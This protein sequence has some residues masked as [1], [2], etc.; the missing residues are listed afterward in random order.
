M[1]R[2][3]TDTVPTMLT[4]GEFVI[5][6]EAVDM[7][8]VPFLKKLN[9]VADNA[10]H[11]SIDALIAQAQMESMKTMKGGGEVVQGY[12]NGGNVE[13]EGLL[14]GL[15]SMLSGVNKRQKAYE[16]LVP[17][18]MIEDAHTADVKY[19]KIPKQ[20]LS[21]GIDPS[22]PEGVTEVV[23]PYRNTHIP[24]FP[25]DFIDVGL[26]DMRGGT[27]SWKEMFEDPENLP[28]YMQ[29]YKDGGEIESK[30]LKDM[31]D[32]YLP[33]KDDVLPYLEFITG[34][35]AETEDYK[36]GALDAALAIPVVG[37][38]GKGIKKLIKSASA[39]RTLKNI[40][41]QDDLAK[42]SFPDASGETMEFSGK[43]I[44]SVLNILDGRYPRGTI[45]SY[46]KVGNRPAYKATVSPSG[47]FTP[48]ELQDG[49]KIQGY[50]DG[51]QVVDPNDLGISQRMAN[52]SVYQ[53]SVIS[54]AG[55]GVDLDTMAQN[56][57]AQDMDAAM[58][59]MEEIK[60]QGIYNEP[61]EA[62]YWDWKGEVPQEKAEEYK[63]VFSILR[64]LENQKA[65]NQ[66]LMHSGRMGGNVRPQ[67]GL[68]F[69]PK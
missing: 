65:L 15:L 47:R 55:G 1:A 64:D 12:E 39:K 6:R 5:K 44:G 24:S 13:K 36:P 26:P 34:A 2:A 10:S 67:E 69:K 45:V 59:L 9:T 49:G 27:M 21:T 46:P 28:L 50:Q 54:G 61:G 20:F 30:T 8:G 48:S 51:E 41:K 18:D 68:F 62:G 38:V 42:Y 14:A 66:M 63:Q 58:Q 33:R 31:L 17:Q 52:P 60:L 43:N 57:V 25:Q 53:G 7:L 32:P 23:S 19:F 16:E 56:Q 40:S 35:S 22:Y 4:P 29:G 11:N 37:G 3:T